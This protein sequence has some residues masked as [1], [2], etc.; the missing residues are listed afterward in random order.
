MFLK[1]YGRDL[2]P[3][4]R[5]ARVLG[6]LA[7]GAACVARFAHEPLRN[8]GVKNV[9][10]LYVFV[11]Q[12]A[13][14]SIAG[15]KFNLILPQTVLVGGAIGKL[16]RKRQILHDGGDYFDGAIGSRWA[17]GG[18]VRTLLLTSRSTL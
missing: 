7:A 15:E 11:T 17:I 18:D 2:R 5:S 16:R 1:H 4:N 3:L 8:L 9:V 13:P 14:G 12:D 6:S 10:K